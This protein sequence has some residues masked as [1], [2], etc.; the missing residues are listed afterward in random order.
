MRGIQPV[1][2]FP[3]IFPSTITQGKLLFH[4]MC[5][6][7]ISKGNNSRVTESLRSSVVGVTLIYWAEE[8]Y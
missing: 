6:R 3:L 4:S 8:N 7:I 1:L 2:F 5:Q